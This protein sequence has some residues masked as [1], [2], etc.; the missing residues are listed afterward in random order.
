M[1]KGRPIPGKG[2][3]HLL[4]RALL[5]PPPRT[6]PFSGIPTSWVRLHS[7]F[8]VRLASLHHAENP[9][10]ASVLWGRCSSFAGGVSLWRV[11]FLG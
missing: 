1:K 9:S 5:S 11:R 2:S 8:V 3:E 7:L 10:R 6:A 4:G